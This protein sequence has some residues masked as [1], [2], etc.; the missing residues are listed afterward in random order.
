MV[1]LC[2]P[3]ALSCVRPRPID[4]ILTLQLDA[5]PAIEAGPSRCAGMV[6][7]AYPELH[8]VGEEHRSEGEGVRTYGSDEEGGDL[9][10]NEGT[11]GGEL[12]E[13]R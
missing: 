2:R 8:A 11:A 9:G 6:G 10:M 12:Q 13:V 4:G 7:D 1:S 3:H 5:T